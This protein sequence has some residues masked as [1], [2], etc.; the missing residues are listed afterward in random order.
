MSCYC[1]KVEIGVT[2]AH[3]LLFSVDV[4]STVNND[5]LDLSVIGSLAPHETELLS[6]IIH[7][8]DHAEWSVAGVSVH[9]DCHPATKAMFLE[10][11][12]HDSSCSL[13]AEKVNK[14]KLMH[15]G[16]CHYN[17]V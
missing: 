10:H 4:C 3:L 8:E 5:V 11:V 6:T 2:L 14:L 16:S 1:N 15:R 9:R 17:E 12:T 7:R 13:S